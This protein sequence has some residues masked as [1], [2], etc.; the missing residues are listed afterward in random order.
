MDTLLIQVTNKKA[1]GLLHELEELHL[2]KVLN[3]KPPIYVTDEMQDSVAEGNREWWKDKQFV[4]ELDRRY[5]AM[6]SGE[7]K[8]VTLEE[9]EFS[10]EK[11]RVKKYG[12]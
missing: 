5:A 11:L 10:I 12:K 1:L 9:L 4:A 8:G 6:E 2:I 3:E 7:D